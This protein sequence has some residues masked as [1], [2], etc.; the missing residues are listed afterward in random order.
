MILNDYFLWRHVFAKW[1]FYNNI[2]IVCTVYNTEWLINIL[3]RYVYCIYVDR[4]K[5]KTSWNLILP[6][7][8]DFISNVMLTVIRYLLSTRLT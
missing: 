3:I 7:M 1:R 2:L 5:S 4:C 6:G 8:W